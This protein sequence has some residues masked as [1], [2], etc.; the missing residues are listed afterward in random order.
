MNVEPSPPNLATTP[1]H[2]PYKHTNKRI[3][4]MKI[5]DKKPDAWSIILLWCHFLN[6]D[7]FYIFAFVLQNLEKPAL[8]EAQRLGRAS[9]EGM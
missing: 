7:L 6:H 5:I 8:G 2:N 3:F 4:T 9:D 1:P